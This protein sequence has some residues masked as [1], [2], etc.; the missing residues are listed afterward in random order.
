MESL[1]MFREAPI[2]TVIIAGEPWYVMPD[3][4]RALGY[5]PD[6]ALR[7]VH[8]SPCLMAGFSRHTVMVGHETNKKGVSRLVRRHVTILSGPGVNALLMKMEESRI[9]DAARVDVLVAMQRWLAITGDRVRR[10]LPLIEHCPDEI[11]QILSI[12]HGSRTD[13]VIELAEQEGVSVNTIWRRVRKA[14]SL[15]SLSHRQTRSDKGRI[16]QGN[17]GDYQRV[18]A[19]RETHPKAGGKEILEA[20]GLKVSVATINRWILA[21]PA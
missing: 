19:Y 11:Q 7:L 20:L 2:R 21:K 15:K 4:A 14:R 3:I 17:G 10:G 16:A 6:V 5:R 12:P 1:S 8:R 18:M 13:A 9:K